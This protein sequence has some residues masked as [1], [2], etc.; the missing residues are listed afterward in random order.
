M[1]EITNNIKATWLID[2]NREGKGFGSTSLYLYSS[3]KILMSCGV[4]LV[5]QDV[6]DVAWEPPS[7]TH[8]AVPPQKYN[9]VLALTEAQ[10]GLHI[11]PQSGQICRGPWAS[12]GSWAVSKVNKG[13]GHSIVTLSQYDARSFFRTEK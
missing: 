5:V 13:Q 1:E 4:E 11:L 6:T 7:F 10:T 12:S 3:L 8:P 9:I 2:T